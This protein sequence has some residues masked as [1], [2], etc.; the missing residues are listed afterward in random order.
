MI[1]SFEMLEV[2]INDSN[3]NLTREFELV[4]NFEDISEDR[5]GND[6]LKSCEVV[7]GNSAE[8]VKVSGML[9]R[10]FRNYDGMDT[11]N[12]TKV[13]GQKADVVYALTN[14]SG[15]VYYFLT[16]FIIK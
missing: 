7:I 11:I 2:V 3:F 9:V 5:I 16:W 15:E 12:D 6:I 14:M 1:N 4:Q 10:K 8:N 13:C